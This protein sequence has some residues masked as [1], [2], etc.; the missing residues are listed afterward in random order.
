MITN[1]S[2]SF[3]GGLARAIASLRAV[4]RVNN[5]PAQWSR[6]VA[7]LRSAWPHEY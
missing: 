1:L 2:D 5:T 4:L 6:S 3:I 7:V